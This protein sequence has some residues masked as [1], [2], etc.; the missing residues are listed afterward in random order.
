MAEPE[1]QTQTLSLRISEALRQRLE[2][3]AIWPR[4]EGR[5]QSGQNFL[6]T[7]CATRAVNSVNLV[8][9]VLV[10]EPM[11]LLMSLAR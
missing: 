2:R 5:D 1:L 11:R 6:S 8:N 3:S 10:K 4:G 9:F 7:R